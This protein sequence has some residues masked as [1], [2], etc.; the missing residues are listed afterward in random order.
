MK[1][2][3]N[4]EITELLK[5][6]MNKP[7]SLVSLILDSFFNTITFLVLLVLKLTGISIIEISWFWVFF[8]LWYTSALVVVVI[9]VLIITLT[10]FSIVEAFKNK[11][12]E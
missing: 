2:N 1:D 3:N 11:K 12:G 10:I 5:E 4:I 6:E 9:I 8:P 7:I